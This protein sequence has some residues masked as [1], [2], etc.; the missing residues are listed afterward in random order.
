MMSIESRGYLD[1][2]QMPFQVVG[3][4]LDFERPMVPQLE[5]PS[6]HVENYFLTAEEEISCDL[7]A[8]PG[9]QA[10]RFE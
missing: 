7:E 9:L 2:V 5:Q 4:L 6:E 3:K 10:P 8:Q 1:R